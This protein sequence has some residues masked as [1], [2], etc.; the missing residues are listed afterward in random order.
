MVDDFL[1]SD[2]HD[3][4]L[5]LRVFAARAKHNAH[6]DEIR[7]NPFLRGGAKPTHKL[8][9]SMT[10]QLDESDLGS[11]SEMKVS[12]FGA[13]AW[14]TA[15]ALVLAENNVETKLWTWESEHA[16]EIRRSGRNTLLPG[17]E[18]DPRIQ[19]T[20]DLA[21]AGKD[22]E[23]ILLVI[24]SQV[25]RSTLQ[26]LREHLNSCRGVICA[27]KGIEAETQ[28]LMSEVVSQELNTVRSTPLSFTAL[29][30]P[31]FA[32]E[33][34]AKVPTNVVAASENPE[35]A[36]EVQHLFSNQWLRVYTGSDVVGVE[37]GGALKNVIAIAAGASEGLGLG[38]NSQAALITRGVAEMARL[39][40]A[41]GGLQLTMA[42]LA[43]MGDL[44]LTC[45]GELSRNRTL[46]FKL[47]KGESV[48]AALHSSQG[49]AEGFVTARSAHLLAQQLGVELPICSAVHAVLHENQPLEAALQ[50]LMERP[51]K[52]E[53]EL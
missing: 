38:K 15:L 22:A 23:L 39:S 2:G 33:V 28:L 18:M 44:V 9:N 5:W 46:G 42:G 37:V 6:D 41:K 30:G 16:N 27:S 20:S 1:T 43:G 47:G 4:S 36:L 35:F 14:G 21:E 17:V 51:L 19:V 11:C 40:Q 12:V 49:V 7:K 31:S 25:V 13:G 26:L 3:A 50:A 34:A 24:P 52:A 48:E 45:T 8:S 53:W 10:R 29:S 32:K